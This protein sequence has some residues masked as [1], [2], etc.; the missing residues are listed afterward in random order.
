[1]ARFLAR[2][3][4][5]ILITVVVVSVIVFFLARLAGDPRN[6]YLSQDA[7]QEQYDA[8]T[9]RFGFDKSLPEQY[10]LFAK[11]IVTG[12][13]G[14]ST[15]ESRPVSELLKS[16]LI[17][18]LQ[19][20]LVA[21]AFSLLISVPMGMYTAVK[22]ASA[23]AQ[24]LK[25]FAMLGQSVPAFWLGIMLIFLFAVVLGWVEASGRSGWTSFVLPVITIAWFNV[26]ASMRLF[27]SSML[28]V[29][30]TEYIKLARAKGVSEIKVFWKHGFRNA[31]IPLLTF[32][33]V[34]LGFI[35][36][37]SIVVEVV[38]AWPG[39]GRLALIAMT[40]GDYPMLQAVVLIFSVSILIASLLVDLIY[41]IVDPRI[42]YA[43]V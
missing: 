9:E 34:N 3:V 2:R 15:R 10:F 20:G 19:L 43:A 33:G 31:L 14:E 18:T 5:T 7:S 42:R 25:V 40:N 23:P 38:F 8:L 41:A 17:A 29:L 6:L 11:G 28:D 12:D 16:P 13:L 37:G 1:M 22:R 36:A 21:F 4:V 32:W 26:A 24:G 30:D 27:R 39:M 35:V